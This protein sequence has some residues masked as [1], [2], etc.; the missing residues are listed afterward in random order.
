MLLF[1]K[2]MLRSNVHGWKMKS[3]PTG[4]VNSIVT[5]VSPLNSLM[6]NQI[7]RLRMSRIQALIIGVKYLRQQHAS[8]SDDDFTMANTKSLCSS[9]ITYLQQIWMAVTAEREIPR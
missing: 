5:V 7:S 6:N 1:A 2:H 3:V 4:V 8:T 9:R